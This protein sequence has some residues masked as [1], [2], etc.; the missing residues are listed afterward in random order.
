MLSWWLPVPRRYLLYPWTE[1]TLMKYHTSRPRFMH[2]HNDWLRPLLSS[3]FACLIPVFRLIFPLSSEF[4]SPPWCCIFIEYLPPGHCSFSINPPLLKPMTLLLPSAST[5]NK[6]YFLKQG[7][8]LPLSG[9][10][11]P[12]SS[13]IFLVSPPQASHHS[14]C[15]IPRA[16]FGSRNYEAGWFKRVGGLGYCLHIDPS[17]RWRYSGPVQICSGM[18]GCHACWIK[19]KE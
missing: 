16:A 13:T 11:S 17:K 5:E 15:S 4:S 3:G 7:D 8:K 14:G 18:W 2:C 6:T 9:H 12:I 10:T 1:N 19:W